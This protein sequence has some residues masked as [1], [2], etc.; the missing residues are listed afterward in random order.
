MIN[1][2]NDEKRRGIIDALNLLKRTK[3]GP[4]YVQPGDDGDDGLPIPNSIKQQ[5]IDIKDDETKNTK[6][7]DEKT[8]S[9]EA[10]AKKLEAQAELDDPTKLQGISDEINSIADR[11]RE[12][13]KKKEAEAKARRDQL[14]RIRPFDVFK[15]E[16][17][18]AATSLEKPERNT[19]H[20]YKKINNK[21]GNTGLLRK[22]TFKETERQEKKIPVF[23][24]LVDRSGSMNGDKMAK[25]ERALKF[26]YDEQDAGKLIVNEYWFG[27]KFGKKGDSVGGSTNEW[28]FGAFV[29]ACI[30]D[31]AENAI[32]FTDSDLSGET[33]D[34]YKRQDWTYYGVSYPPKTLTLPGV[35]FYVWLNGNSAKNL[36]QI[37]KS[38]DPYNT[39]EYELK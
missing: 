3:D 9:P 20:S 15:N 12:F 26:L 11:R 39:R 33:L 7:Y 16:L 25:T 13:A 18:D 32:V 10:I 38:E 21:V 2:T 1:I 14:E 31:K 35:V 27:T 30:A 6:A 37:L 23:N 8:L 28:C 34:W 4:I 5:I 24:V 19:V 22:A 36:K 29:D 17:Y